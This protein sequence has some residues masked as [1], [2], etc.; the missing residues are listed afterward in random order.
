MFL[1]YILSQQDWG[2][3]QPGNGPRDVANGRAV[4]SALHTNF[5]HVSAADLSEFFRIEL[6]GTINGRPARSG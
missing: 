3:T 2:G 4:E 1:A 6:A 5:V